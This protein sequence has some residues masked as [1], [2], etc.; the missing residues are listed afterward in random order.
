M[1][2]TKIKFR[3]TLCNQSKDFYIMPLDEEVGKDD[4]VHS[5]DSYRLTCKI[6]GEDYILKFTI[7]P[8]KRKK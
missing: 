7:K 6:C 5:I 8:L 2:T 1:I 3:C 4:F